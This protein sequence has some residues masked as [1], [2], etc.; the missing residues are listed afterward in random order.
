MLWLYEK[1]NESIR[2]E[3]R[4]DNDTRE[5]VV[6]VHYPDGRQ[7]EERFPNP[8][9]CREWLLSLENNLDA[10][11]WVRRGPPMILPDGWPRPE[12]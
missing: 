5:Y 11:H 8:E 3:T 1:D 7:L 10:E 6:V 4:Y 9:A 2:L 12:K